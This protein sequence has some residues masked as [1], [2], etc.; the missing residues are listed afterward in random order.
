[1]SAPYTAPA[2]PPA[3]PRALLVDD[4]P[5][6]RQAL[7]RFFVRMG[8]E[9]DEAEDGN[10]ALRLLLG[11]R[12]ACYAV[13]ISDLRMPGVS[14]IELHARLTEARPQ[15]LERLILSTGDSVSTEAAEFL[16]RSRCPV[17]NKPFELAE[18]RAMIARVQESAGGSPP[19]A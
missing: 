7:R 14:G 1:M 17:L 8:W 15:L 3:A 12:S 19:A 6:I 11:E 13:I 16:R 9:V 18:L 2:A 5:V 10:E 4:E